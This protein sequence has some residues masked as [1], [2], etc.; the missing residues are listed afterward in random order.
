[1]REGVAD[2]FVNNYEDYFYF[3]LRHSSSFQ[4][5]EEVMQETFLRLYKKNEQ[6]ENPVSRIKRSIIFA[7]A[8]FYREYY[9]ARRKYRPIFESLDGKVGNF[10]ES[11]SDFD[12]GHTLPLDVELAIATYD[13]EKGQNELPENL[14]KAL[15]KTRFGNLFY[16]HVVDEKTQ[17][18]LAKE[19]GVSNALICLRISETKKQLEEILQAA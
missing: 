18:E 12:L 16:M 13:A 11:S 15:K 10:Q 7:A 1:M 9:G 3:A 2:Y 4:D 19:C 17:A 14:T 5:A 8:D 6:L